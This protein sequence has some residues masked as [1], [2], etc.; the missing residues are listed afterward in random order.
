MR[1]SRGWP[2]ALESG[3]VFRFLTGAALAGVYPLGMKLVVS[4]APEKSG[5]ALGWLIGALTLGTSLPHWTRGL[6]QHWPWQSVVLTSSILALAAAGLILWQGDGPHLP[7]KSSP[8][9]GEAMRV[10]RRPAFRASAFG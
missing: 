3:L 5:L 9:W 2:A 10:F 8:S 4:W 1:V 7:R 6:G